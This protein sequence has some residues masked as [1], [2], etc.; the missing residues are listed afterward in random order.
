MNGL[1]QTVKHKTSGGGR[2][3]DSLRIGIEVRHLVGNCG[4][5]VSSRNLVAAV[6]G[7]SLVYRLFCYVGMQDYRKNLLLARDLACTHPG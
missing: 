7:G 2:G 6:V 5:G 1:E 4:R 3:V